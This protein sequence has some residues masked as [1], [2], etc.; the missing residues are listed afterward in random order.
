MSELD[1]EVEAF[2]LLEENYPQEVK[3]EAYSIVFTSLG[4][5]IEKHQL[6]KTNFP[7]RANSAIY[8]LALALAKKNL[9]DKPEEA[10][11]YLNEQ[12]KRIQEGEYNIIEVIFDEVVKET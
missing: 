2:R 4:R 12:F 10:E 9:V 11:K 1:P 3:D 8:V 6:R 7:K 5:F